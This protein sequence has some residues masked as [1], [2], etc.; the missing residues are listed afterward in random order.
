MSAKKAAPGV[1]K[2]TT[3]V[4]NDP[5]DL[6]GGSP[7]ALAIFQGGGTPFSPQNVQFNP[8][9]L[10]YCHNPGELKCNPYSIGTVLYINYTIDALNNVTLRPEW[11]DDPYGW[12]TG[13]SGRTQY[14]E[15]TISWQHWL[16]PQIEFRP[17]IS[18]WRSIGAPAFNG[19]AIKGI[20]ANKRDTGLFAADVIVH[21]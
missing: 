13:T 9:N 15:T 7:T 12:R 21:F 14:Y 17:E 18:Y 1:T 3:V 16:S 10:V 2:A 4:A 11:Y 5:D 6:E 19:N 8:P 20:V